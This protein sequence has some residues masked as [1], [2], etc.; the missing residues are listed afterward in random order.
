MMV[1]I[2]AAM[3]IALFGWGSDYFGWDDTTGRV[4]L[5][6]FTTFVLGAICGYK[7]RS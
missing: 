1:A 4:Q 3:F 2:P 7:S 5:A 6:M